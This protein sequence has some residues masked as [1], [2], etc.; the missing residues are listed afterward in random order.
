M[1]I[2]VRGLTKVFETGRRRARRR[3]EAVRAI[4][5][6]VEPGERIAYIGPNGAGK[7]T[8]IKILTGILHPTAGE[9]AVLGIV[10]WTDRRRLAARIGTLFGQRSLLWFE[11]TPRQSYRMLAAIYELDRR[12]EAQR[13]GELAELLDAADLFDQPVRS[14]SLGQR[15]RCELAACMLH[16]PEVLFLDEPTIGLDLLAKQRF[17]ELLVRLNVERNTTT[18]LT[19]HDV[20]DIEHVA[21]R[22]IV[23]NHGSVIYDDD[24]AAMRRALLAT[25]LVE[26]G[27]AQPAPPLHL[28]G[29]DV[30]EQTDVK[31]ELVVDTT[32]TSIR[33]VLDTL[34]ATTAVADISVTDPPLEQVIAEIYRQPQT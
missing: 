5:F 12:Q 34:L 3:I 25:K 29:V 9:A 19:S 1:S 15:M 10:P 24:V 7:S 2:Q 11:L 22:A 14:L 32:A 20:A 17:R 8:S 31:A 4:S 28:P 16:E 30:L 6:T 27:L 33:A 21:R 26:V 13:V 18:F 23:I